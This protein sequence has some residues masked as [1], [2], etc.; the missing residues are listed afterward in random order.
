MLFLKNDYM[1]LQSSS[2][3]D[4]V[5]IENPKVNNREVRER[6]NILTWKKIPFSM[7]I[8]L[9]Q[10]KGKMKHL[11][12]LKC[13]QEGGFLVFQILICFIVFCWP[14]SQ[15][16]RKYENVETILNLS[17]KTDFIFLISRFLTVNSGGRGVMKYRIFLT[18]SLF[19]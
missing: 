12:K 4:S 3:E 17:L 2:R 11:T 15:V 14:I 5:T 16:C 19:C 13:Q 1:Y 10:R 8:L 6:K 9:S 7:T 18:F